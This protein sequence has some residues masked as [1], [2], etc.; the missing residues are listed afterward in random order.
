VH[1]PALIDFEK[2]SPELVRGVKAPSSVNWEALKMVVDHACDTDLKRYIM[3][4]RLRKSVKENG[5]AYLAP[6]LRYNYCRARLTLGDFSDYWGWEFRDYG[7]NGHSWAAHMYWEETWL[8]KWG[9]GNCNRLLVLGE[10]GIGDA[11][12]AASILPDAMIRCREV[13]FECDER[14]HSLLQRSLPGLRCEKERGFEDRRTDYGVVDAFIPSFELMRMFRRSISSFP[15]L[16]YLKAAPWKL[17][18]VEKYRGRIGISWKARQ[19]S[20]DP[21]KL[22]IEN[23]LSVQYTHTH[24]E[25]EPPEIDLFND[26]EGIVALISVLKKV[27]CVPTSVHH[28]AGALGK[29]VEIISPENRNQDALNLSPWDYSTRYNGGNL[30]WYLNA[31]VF[32]SLEKWKN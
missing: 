16:P 20:I 32:E 9:G 18:A 10:Q 24:P 19:G 3:W 28:I 29:R 5:L 22:G 6:A 25:V 8:P 7:A 14:L 21:M 11:I 4:K 17:E 12:F 31:Q 13:I 27:V 30:P 1:S 2:H 15:G 26:I 23:P